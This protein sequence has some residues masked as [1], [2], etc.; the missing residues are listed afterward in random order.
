VTH[1]EIAVVSSADDLHALAVVDL[2]D[3]SPDVTAHL[4][5]A[6]RV[7]FQESLTWMSRDARA[8][9]G[10]LLTAAGDRVDVGACG[11]VWWRR[12]FPTQREAGRLPEE[13]QQ[14]L[15]NRSCAEALLGLLLS[16]FSGAWVNDP[17]C[18]RTAANK[19]VQSVTAAR[20]GFRV[21]RTLVSQEPERI[22]EFYDELDGRVVVKPVAGSPRSPLLTQHVRPEHLEVA[23]PLVA[24]PAIYQELIPGSVHLRVNCFGDDVHA[25]EIRTEALDWR[26]DLGVPMSAV[27]LAPDLRDRIRSVLD[28]LGLRMGIVDLKVTPDGE[29]VWLEV[30]PQGQFLFLQPLVEVDYLEA[31]ARF[32][33]AEARGAHLAAAPA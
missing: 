20:S 29:P 16:A 12:V 32:L 25:V 30:N 5:E 11:A 6:D 13:G 33:V 4:V 22:R 14:D 3:R 10:R 21:P 8:P 18:T 17:F 15:L 24:M 2:L 23:G 19:L 26:A 7:A 31:F 27:P 1:T 28:C 9:S